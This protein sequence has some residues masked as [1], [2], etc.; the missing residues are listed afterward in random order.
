MPDTG[1]PWY[2]PYPVAGDAPDDPTQSRIRAEQIHANLST[3][4][5]N[6]N[7]VTARLTLLGKV[8]AYTMQVSDPPLNITGGANDFTNAAWPYPTFVVPP[9]GKFRV[10]FAADVQNINSATSTCH[11]S[12]RTSIAGTIPLS[13]NASIAGTRAILS[14]V[15]Y[16][17][18]FTPGASCQVIP[19]WSISSG[20]SATAF[21]HAGTCLVEAY[22]S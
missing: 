7:A 11:L 22:D 19:I 8:L 10:T 15:S 18:G 12:F 14:R 20:S 21:I 2:I 4:N 5:V 16:C 3:L 13:P 9:S 1:A 6:L 17:T